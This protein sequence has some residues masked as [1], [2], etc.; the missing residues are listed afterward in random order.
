MRHALELMLAEL[1]ENRLEVIVLN[2]CRAV[3][4]E[5]CPWYRHFC[6]T[7]KS[8]RRRYPRPRTII[9]R[10]ATIRALER[11]LAGRFDSIYAQRLLPL[12][13]NLAHE[14]G[15]PPPDCSFDTF[16]IPE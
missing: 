16:T 11:M 14:L 7:H 15:P 9:K 12:A 6:D 1:R 4:S 13:E 3:V 5:N 2:D 8:P 10:Y